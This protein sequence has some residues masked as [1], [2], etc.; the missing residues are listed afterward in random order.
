MSFSNPAGNAREAANS[1]VRALLEL[2]GKRD[3]IGILDDVIPQIE[4]L[5]RKVSHE[6]LHRPEAPGKWSMIQVIQHLGD[7]DLVVGYRIRKILAED[8]PSIE[9][10]DQDRWAASLHYDRAELKEA[11]MQLRG[12]RTGNLR[13]IRSLSDKERARTGIHAERGPESV[14][15]LTELAAAH[16]LVHRNQLARIKSKL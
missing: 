1:Y 14:W 10:F 12:V 13:L 8:N 6:N 16:D 5:T 7:T 11:I 2:L 15:R 4:S 3:P 9:G